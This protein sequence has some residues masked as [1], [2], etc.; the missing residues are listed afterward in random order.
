M[1][2]E[3]EENLKKEELQVE[4]KNCILKISAWGKGLYRD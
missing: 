2:V 4:N 3:G 1:Y